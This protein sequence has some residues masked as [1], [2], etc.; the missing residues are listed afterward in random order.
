MAPLPN[1]PMWFIWCLAIS[2]IFGIIATVVSTIVCAVLIDTSE[3]KRSSYASSTEN[4]RWIMYVWKMTGAETI[5]YYANRAPSTSRNVHTPI[6][7]IARKEPPNTDSFEGEIIGFIEDS[8]GWPFLAFACIG[9]VDN[10][11]VFDKDDMENSFVL[12]DKWGARTGIYPLWPKVI[13]CRPLWLGVFKNAGAYSLVFFVMLGFARIML[14]G[15]RIAEGT[16]P[17]CGYILDEGG[18]KGCPECGWGR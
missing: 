2:I 11:K 14:R 17:G 16:C 7:S 8:R 1:Q 18:S 6:W 9:R 10:F 3:G 12:K 5:S 13:P 15:K 4:P